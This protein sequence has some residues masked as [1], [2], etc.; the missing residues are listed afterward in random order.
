MNEQAILDLVSPIVQQHGLE[1]DRVE[2]LGVGRQTLLRISL[3]GDGPAGRGP[4][5]DQ[6]TQATR[7]ISAALDDSHATVPGAYTLEVSSRGVS[8]PLTEPKH[9]RRNI[10]RLV[11]L[12]VAGAAGFTGRITGATDDAV[13]LDV[14]GEARTVALADITR[15]V[16]KAELTKGSAADEPADDEEE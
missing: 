10:A 16:V 12:D 2:A 13:D 4:S 11:K 15:A 1:V 14:D 9:F 6:I 3:D 5:L 8:R 7:A